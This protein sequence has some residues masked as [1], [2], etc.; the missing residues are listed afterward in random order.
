VGL[1]THRIPTKGF[2]GVWT[3]SFPLSQTFLAQGRDSILTCIS[4]RK[5]I[6]GRRI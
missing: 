3:T 6:E 2:S 1:V 4:G 5:R